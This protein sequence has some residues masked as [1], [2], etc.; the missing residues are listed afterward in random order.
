VVFYVFYEDT[1]G[2]V[3][4]IEEHKIQPFLS[5]EKHPS[6]PYANGINGHADRPSPT[7]ATLKRLLKAYEFADL[8]TLALVRRPISQH[9]A[10]DSHTVIFTFGKADFSIDVERVSFVSISL[11]SPLPSSRI[12]KFIPSSTPRGIVLEQVQRWSITCTPYL[13]VIAALPRH[14]PGRHPVVQSGYLSP[15]TSTTTVNIQKLIERASSASPSECLSLGSIS[16]TV[17]RSDS[18]NTSRSET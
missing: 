7:D 10:S 13:D 8:S 5:G 15:S 6:K 3:N 2:D 18:R 1:A 12:L 17:E 4:E 16:H 11:L 9:G 14:A